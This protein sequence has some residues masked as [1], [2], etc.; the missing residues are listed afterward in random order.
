VRRLLPAVLALILMGAACGDSTSNAA[1]GSGT[2]STTASSNGV[3]KTVE[4]ADVALDIPVD[5]A[6]TQPTLE[7]GLVPPESALMVGNATFI[8]RLGT[9]SFGGGSCGTAPTGPL[10][11]LGRGE[12]MILLQVT[13]GTADVG[14]VDAGN[15]ALSGPVASAGSEV[16]DCFRAAD[17]VDRIEWIEGQAA[18][19]DIAVLVVMGPETGEPN[20]EQVREVLGSIRPRR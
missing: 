15:A 4:V 1:G 14:L 12:V 13:D 7:P 10:F 17:P 20:R 16:A 3:V 8:A 9:R 11:E 5:W 2:V 19:H 18:G 6:I